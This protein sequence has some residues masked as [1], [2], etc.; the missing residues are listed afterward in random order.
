MGRDG[1]SQLPSG[2]VCTIL[3]R[4]VRSERRVRRRLSSAFAS[5]LSY[6]Y[7]T[8]IFC[9]PA[10]ISRALGCAVEGSALKALLK[11]TAVEAAIARSTIDTSG[12]PDARR[13]A[14]QRS[15]RA[16]AASLCGSLS[17]GM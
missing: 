14:L 11:N 9:A 2:I 10:T 8:R 7:S 15:V 1:Y 16:R 4:E 3:A 5:R 6:P 17:L 13:L 12:L